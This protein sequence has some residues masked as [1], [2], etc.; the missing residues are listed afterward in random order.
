MSKIAY[1]FVD[2]HQIKQVLAELHA[3]FPKAIKGIQYLQVDKESRD[4]LFGKKPRRSNAPRR[5]LEGLL[6]DGFNAFNGISSPKSYHVLVIDIAE[7]KIDNRFYNVISSCG[8]VQTKKRASWFLDRARAIF[9][10]SY[11]LEALL[12]QLEDF[13]EQRQDPMGDWFD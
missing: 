10:L 11:N 3:S 1:I 7:T 2:F 13:H 6:G 8:G 4:Y 5:M 9:N 12:V